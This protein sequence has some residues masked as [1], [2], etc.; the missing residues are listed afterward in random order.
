MKAYSQDLREHG[1]RAVDDGSPRAEIV[2]MFG[3]SLSTLE[4]YV[5]Q[6]REE[7]HV[8]PKTIPGRPPKKRAQVEA[9]VLPQLQANADATLE[10]HCEMWKQTHGEDV[11]RWTMSRAIKRLGWTRKKSRSG[12]QGATKRSEP[13]GERTRASS[14]QTIWCLLM[15]VAPTLHACLYMR[16]PP[17]GNEPGEVFRATAARIRRSSP[18]S[19]EGMGATLIL[20]GSANT[21]AFE[22]YIEQVLAPSLHAGQ[23]VVMDNLQAHKSAWVRQ[24][25]EAKGCQL[26][27]LPGYSPDLSPIEEAFSKLKTALRRAG[28]RTREALQ[29]AISQ[30]LLTITVKSAQG[31]FQHCGYLLPEQERKS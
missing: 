7:G 11:S 30:A 9:G 17:R 28:V 1:L 24:A 27:F 13:L 31:W 10:Q 8:R 26:L 4:R 3:I 15:S 14:R 19:L 5:K 25:I 23:I 20:E 22:L 21:T 12:R 18:P 16:V 29:E 2:Q 6:R